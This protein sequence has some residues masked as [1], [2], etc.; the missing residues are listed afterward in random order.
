MGG[1]ISSIKSNVLDFGYEAYK[2]V[3]SDDRKG[4]EF[5]KYQAKTKK[6]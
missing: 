2:Y 1:L 4:I 5:F 3:Y 6:I